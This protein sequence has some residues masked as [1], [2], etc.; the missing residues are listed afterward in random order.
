MIIWFITALVLV[1]AEIVTLN[2]VFA[3]FA[4]GSAVACVAALASENFLIQFAALVIGT[5]L[6]L[7]IVRPVVLAKLYT[8]DHKTGFDKLIGQ[9]GTA[10]ETI[11]LETG[12]M[13]MHGDV[14]TARTES[15][16]IPAGNQVTLK[17]VV[18]A[19]AIVEKCS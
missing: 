15:G 14:W 9:Q 12:S 3:S 18:G 6:S 16:E 2:L 5:L 13:R 4:V 11:T 8:R 7:F 17:K 19:I 1:I 10:L